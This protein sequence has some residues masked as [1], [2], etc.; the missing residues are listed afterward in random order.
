MKR[1]FSFGLAVLGL[2]LSAQATVLTFTPGQTLYNKNVA[3]GL[4]VD[5]DTGYAD[6]HEFKIHPAYGDN[7]SASPDANGFT[8]GSPNTPHVT[9]DY[10]PNTGPTYGE[11]TS[12]RVCTPLYGSEWGPNSWASQ[13][14]N[15]LYNGY[16]VLPGD[17]TGTQW[18]LRFTAAPGYA[19]QVNSFEMVSQLA[20][21]NPEDIDVFLDG[22]V[23]PAY[24]T[25]VNLP[26]NNLASPPAPLLI[27]LPAV[28]GQEVIVRMTDGTAN[29]SAASN[30]NFTEIAIPEPATMGLLALAGLALLRRR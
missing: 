4:Y 24:H 19:V 22:S 18:Q 27:S 12:V 23:I 20:E 14:V 11:M 17:A 28:Q 29:Y 7:V 8:Y 2:T 13:G 5:V 15:F 16:G 25:T 6:S 26:G 21:G 30:F 10:E 9:V 3:D 1:V